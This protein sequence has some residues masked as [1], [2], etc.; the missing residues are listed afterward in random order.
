[1]DT[2][3]V[4]AWAGDPTLSSMYK[5]AG[6]V[7]K[8]CQEV[9]NYR[10]HRFFKTVDTRYERMTE[11]DRLK[12]KEKVLSNAGQK[13]TSDYVAAVLNSPS[14]IVNAAL[15]LVYCDDQDFGLSEREK[16]RFVDGVN[17]L[18]DEKVNFF[19]SL[20][21]LNPLSRES[22]IEAFSIYKDNIESLDAEFDEVFI[23]MSDFISRGLVVDDINKNDSPSIGDIGGAEDWAV[24][25]CLSGTQKKFASILRKAKELIR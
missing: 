20:L 13:F 22:A 10:I 25:F 9:V 8:A 19:L 23:Y 1:M 15:A 21:P 14:M 2:N 6:F 18:T 24:I 12:F 5:S 4:T 3:E 11:E 17:G 16:R 7:V